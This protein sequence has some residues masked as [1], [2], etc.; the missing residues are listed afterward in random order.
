[1]K[2]L[3]LAPLAAL[4]ALALATALPASAAIQVFTTTLSGAAEAPTNS[5]AG[6][7]NATVTVNDTTFSMRVQSTFSGL[8]GITSAAHIHCC[9]AAAG[10]GTAGVATQ[11]PSFTGFPLLVTSGSMDSFFDLTLPGSWNAAFI[12][13]NG[14]TTAS[15][16]TTFLSGL[17][18]G[19]TYFNVHTSAFPAG[20]IR[21]FLVSAVPEPETYA[22]MLVGLLGVGWA[23]RRRRAA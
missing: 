2:L 14:G 6:T 7:G 8:T 13:A 3:T 12:T 11:T 20:E 17:N 19:R 1:M 22:L 18:T 5:S 15:A 10:T 16:F 23:A 4:A 21:G 9:T